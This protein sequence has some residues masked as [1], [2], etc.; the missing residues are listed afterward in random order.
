VGDSVARDVLMAKQADVFAIWAAYGAQH[1]RRV[2]DDL[3]RIS[4]WTAKDVALEQELR[5]RA[6]AV[7]PDFT[8]HHSFAEVLI[9]TRHSGAGPRALRD[10]GHANH[11]V[12]SCG[13]FPTFIH[14]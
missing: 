2:Y 9:P 13:S 10:R 5:R 6:E 4:H 7:K 8:A 11:R 3:V 12:G 1:D 14:V